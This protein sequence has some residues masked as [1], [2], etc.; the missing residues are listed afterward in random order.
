MLLHVELDRGV[1]L[2]AGRGLR[3][4]HRQDEADLDAVLRGGRERC[5]RGHRKCRS[6]DD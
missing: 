2:L 3:A 4:G 1:D 5:E 6:T